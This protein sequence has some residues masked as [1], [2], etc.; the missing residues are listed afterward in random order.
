MNRG[1]EVAGMWELEGRRSPKVSTARGSLWQGNGGKAEKSRSKENK[2]TKEMKENLEA[3]GKE[4]AGIKGREMGMV[5][6]KEIA[7]TPLWSLP[8]H[9]QKGWARYSGEENQ[10]QVEQGMRETTQKCKEGK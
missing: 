7:V 10:A 3:K 8:F 5:S 1:C 4:R 6:Q 9:H 2:R